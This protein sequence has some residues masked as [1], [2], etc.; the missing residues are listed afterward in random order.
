[1]S[2]VTDGVFRRL[3]RR[4]GA[5]LTFTEMV[6][7]NG[8]VRGNEA[9]RKLAVVGADEGPVGVQLFGSDPSSM[10]EAA[11]IAE[12]L[13]ASLVDI[14]MGCPVPKVTRC[15]GGAA[16]MLDPPRAAR[17]VEGVRAAVRV[18]VTVKMRKGWDDS[19]CDTASFA[20][21]L[22][23]AGACALTIHGRTRAQGY[24]GSPDWECIARAKRAVSVPVIGNGDVDG[25]ATML[26]MLR[27]TGCDAVM[28]GR[29]ALGNPWI[30]REIAS[31]L[32]GG[33]LSVTLEERVNTALEHL[34][35]MTAEYGER[36]AVIKMRKHLAWYT[37]GLPGA[38]RLRLELTRATTVAEMERIL[39][40]IAGGR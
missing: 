38:S 4:F 20:A 13:G 9:S 16:L 1:M 29:A 12:A 14:N 19:H 39:E 28:V 37:R 27:E 34:M 30:F 36:S 25:V 8:L 33:K 11:V 21:L 23:S 3:N 15:G 35:M 17:I 31:A 24:S 22:E 5:P 7:D 18:P 2:G 32:S 26:R 10:A 6:S 40:T